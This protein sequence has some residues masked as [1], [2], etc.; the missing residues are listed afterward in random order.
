MSANWTPVGDGVN[1]WQQ[2]TEPKS[3]GTSTYVVRK[4]GQTTSNPHA[5]FDYNPK[6]GEYTYNHSS[7][8]KQQHSGMREVMLTAVSFLKGKGLL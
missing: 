5:C 4:I 8:S 7:F 3:D 6:T 1:E 2:K